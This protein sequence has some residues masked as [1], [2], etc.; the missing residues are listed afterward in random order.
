M[1]V[2]VLVLVVAFLSSVSVELQ[3][4]KKYSSG[5]DARALADSA[6][7]LVISQIQDATAKPQL[8]WASQPGMIR[9]YT[10]SGTLDTAYKLYSSGQLR[11]SGSV[12][13]AADV[14]GNWADSAALFT[15]LNKPVAVAGVNRYPIIDPTAVASGT[16]GGAALSGTSRP[17]EGC[18][19]DTGNAAVA[20]SAT[21][22]NPVPMPVQWMY[23]LNS[24]SLAAMNPATQIVAGASAS[25]P[26]VGRIAFWTDDESSKVNINTASEGTFWDR[27][28]ASSGTTGFETRLT[29]T[30]PA[31]NEFQRFPGHPAMTSLSVIFPALS[32]E[33]ADQYNARLYSILPRVQD[34]GSKSGTV[35]VNY[36]TPPILADNERLFG[37]VDEFFFSATALSSG[38]RVVNPN[39]SGS[40][41]S[42]GDIEKS[43]FFITAN[44]RSPEVNM[45]NKPRVTLW[46]LQLD[47]EP[48]TGKATRTA[49]DKLIAFCST[50]GVGADAKEYFFQRYSTYD[51]SKN[52]PND[53]GAGPYSPSQN[54]K[55]SS[56]SPALDWNQ[57]TRN[58][59]VYAYLQSLT[60]APIPGFGGSLS[61]PGGKYNSSTRDQILTEMLDFV[62]SNINVTTTGIA[63]TSGTSGYSYAP[64]NPGNTN[65]WTGQFQVVPLSL[66]NGTKGFGNFGTITQAA[67]VF[68]RSDNILV[69][70]TE[71][72]VAQQKYTGGVIPSAA[73]TS[74]TNPH[75]SAFL[76]LQPFT[77][78]PGPPPWSANMRIRV[79]GLDQFL[80][81]S[82]TVSTSLG[83]PADAINLVT[84]RDGQSNATPFTGLE[85]FTQYWPLNIKRPGMSTVGAANE[86]EFYPFVS[87]A[88][89]INGTSF[90]LE[91]GS[92]TIEIYS[93]YANTLD[94]EDLVQT[95][96]MNFPD[97][98]G[99][100][101]P[102]ISWS[103]SDSKS[104]ST[105][106]A[107]DQSTITQFNLLTTRFG[108][109]QTGG[110]Y[111]VQQNGQHN[112][113]PLIRNEDTVRAVEA[114]HGGPAR[115]DYR[116]IA[117]LKNVPDS[118][119]EGHGLLDTPEDGKR[120][121]D[122]AV[123]SRLIHSLR[124]DSGAGQG[125]T[126]F[127]GGYY[128]GAGRAGKLLAA[129]N[130]YVAT[131]NPQKSNRAPAVP[132]GLAQAD[133]ANG[134][135]GDWDTGIGS[136]RDGPFINKADLGNVG[137][138]AT[139]TNGYYNA[140]G[141]D[142]SA[143]SAV[144]V[145][146]G[147]SFSPNRQISSAV[148]FGSLPTG[149]DPSDPA[150]AK[151]WQTLLFARNPL[152]GS[153][154]PGFGVPFGGPPYNVPPDHLFLDFF[155]MPI[156]EPYAI[157][158]PFSTAGKVNMNYQIFPF[159]YLTRSTGVRAVLKSTRMM[160]IP[161]ANAINYKYDSNSGQTVGAGFPPDF[162]YTINPDE[163]TGTLAGFEERFGSGDIFRSASEIC[164]IFLVPEKNV[165]GSSAPGSP[166]YGTMANWWRDYELTGDNVREGPYSHVY[167]RLTTK[168]NTFTVHV[169]AQSIA[170]ANGTA[171]NQFVEG[172]DQV[173]GEFRGSF[174]IE[175]YLDP[176]SDSL[177]NSAGDPTNELDPDG[178][179]GPYKFRVVN[180]KRFAP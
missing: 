117:G 156:V 90:G 34:G 178:M 161:T 45:F 165:D 51:N 33:T 47:P 40:T 17:I 21:Q 64:F 104:D 27:P 148:S 12:N 63:T 28:W 1:L 109:T 147:A 48:I 98:N 141:H 110:G 108:S 2:L 142:R 59:D 102:L 83:F 159:T 179:V 133:M 175:R 41:F 76:V 164:N 11:V 120:Y 62:R 163:T 49:K 127:S 122:T 73:V 144:V 105:L 43:R 151:P 100:P 132:R 31:Q 96:V 97:G 55:P 153:Q 38:S 93:G 140:Q 80:V 111:G 61:G 88:I 154:H 50:I 116:L 176:N 114:R 9:T 166:S 82:G 5:A 150:A 174:L 25:D 94:S 145:D 137:S 158:E 138:N 54:P 79:R 134:V 81:T 46:P 68:F 155:T 4:A 135:L 149:I 20:T 160:A 123:A 121:S 157:S 71:Q 60:A 173:T 143:N 130:Y 124:V 171:P 39:G 101:V 169:M 29:Q 22:I 106:P 3:S 180:T 107:N 23:V 91:G 10:G 86:E 113:L 26:I 146:T 162:R 65:A 16:S 126:S 177:V 66:P 172:K 30:I 58:R 37:T 95:I 118:Y 87:N 167:P 170:K 70:G 99:W 6:V 115:G 18:F 168:S 67:L 129:A 136:R 14:P 69:S 75:M 24:G 35:T 19:L 7:S 85:L 125:M 131:N 92:I 89:P 103:K 15:D 52:G 77:P 56:Q 57:I 112:P 13:P 78:S 119:F 152:G 139:V 8:A 84:A 36:L 72:T 74:G 44:S 42:V 32:G 53:R 128:A